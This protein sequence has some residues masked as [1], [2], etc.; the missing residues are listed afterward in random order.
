[1]NEWINL[2]V[3]ISLFFCLFLSIHLSMC[4]FVCLSF[5][6][7]SLFSFLE[8]RSP[9]HELGCRLCVP[10]I[11]Q[12]VKNAGEARGQSCCSAVPEHQPSVSFTDVP[13]AHPYCPL[14][15][16]KKKKNPQYRTVAV[17]LDKL[18]LKNTPDFQEGQKPL[19]VCTFQHSLKTKAWSFMTRCHL[20]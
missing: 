10:S 11:Q 16:L 20:P 9:V 7:S 19:V 4:T 3:H 2:F 18:L 17:S 13:H 5:C 12:R 1:M 15:V 14:W 6:L 8:W